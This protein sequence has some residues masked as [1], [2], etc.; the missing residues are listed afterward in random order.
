MK[1]SKSK[2]GYTL[3]MTKN[4]KINTIRC[5]SIAKTSLFKLL[6]LIASQSLAQDKLRK[7]AIYYELFGTGL[8]YSSIHY[9]RQLPLSDNL[10]FA[11]GIGFSLTK[12][13]YVG[14]TK[15]LG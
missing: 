6:L 4:M 7:N 8:G 14:G 1:L 15:K 10:I 5:N 3:R 13:V 9:E 2:I 12:T 11:P